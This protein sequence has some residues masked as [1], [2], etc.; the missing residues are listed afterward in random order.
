MPI[1]VSAITLTSW[2]QYIKTILTKLSLKTRKEVA[3]GSLAEVN[4]ASISLV[5]SAI[6]GDIKDKCRSKIP[7][8]WAQKI[9]GPEK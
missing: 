5:V 8:C 9:L 2:S 6:T 7:K 3:A 1:A 4:Q